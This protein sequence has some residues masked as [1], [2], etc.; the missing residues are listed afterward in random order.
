MG[1]E[2]CLHDIKK[3]DPKHQSAYKSR[4]TSIAKRMD[5]Q[6]G[7]DVLEDRIILTLAGESQGQAFWLTR[8]QCIAIIKAC[9]MTEHEDTPA[10]KVGASSKGQPKPQWPIECQPKLAELNLR[11]VA[12]GLRITIKAKDCAPIALLLTPADQIRI[13]R[14]LKQLAIRVQWDIEAA[15]A[16]IVANQALHS[17]LKRLH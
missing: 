11:R 1:F 3:L 5:I 6:L 17:A 13:K 4:Q 15:E 9:Q 12:K 8:R 7:F 2:A 10:P 16:R 14:K